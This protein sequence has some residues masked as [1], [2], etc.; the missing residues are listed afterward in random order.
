MTVIAWDG[1]TLAADRRCSFG[2]YIG[3]MT[4]IRRINADLVGV[5]GTAAKAAEFFEWYRLG[6]D[7]ATYPTRGEAD[8]FNGL[9]IVL[10]PQIRRYEVVGVPFVVEMDKHAIG[11]GRDFAVM[12]MHLGK[13]AAEAVELASVFD[14]QCGNG[15]DLLHL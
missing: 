9:V 2:S 13:T 10:G 1:L 3:S 11:S 7:P 4:K 12:A 15:V 8:Y 14:E 6:A 5:S